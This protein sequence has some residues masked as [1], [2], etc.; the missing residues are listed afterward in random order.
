M[1]VPYTC[2]S[3]FSQMAFL[4]F[5]ITIT[6]IYVHFY[7]GDVGIG[8]KYREKPK[9]LMVCFLEKGEK[10][11]VYDK[12]NQS[13]DVANHSERGER[14]M[15]KR[16][17]QNWRKWENERE[18]KWNQWE[19]IIIIINCHKSCWVKC[20]PFYRFRMIKRSRLKSIWMSLTPGILDYVSRYAACLSSIDKKKYFLPWIDFLLS[21]K[22][23]FRKMLKCHEQHVACHTSHMTCHIPHFVCHITKKNQFFIEF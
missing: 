6:I 10:K 3:P 9:S 1:L 2:F 17:L 12:N 23:I 15:S 11:N 14:E 13:D 4:F 16:L 18:E 7:G 19:I 5:S 21:L 22:L 8:D 20:K